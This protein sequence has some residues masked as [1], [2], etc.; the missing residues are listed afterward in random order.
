MLFSDPFTGARSMTSSDT[1]IPGYELLRELG[2]G[3]M[4]TVWLA[5]QR[6]L[7]RKV[8]IKVMKRNIDDLEKFERRF[9]VEGR[10]MAKLPHRNIVAVYD[11]VKGE[12]VTYIAMEYLDGGTLSTKMKEGLS[13]AEAISVVVQIAHALQ[14]A[15]EHGV[16]HRDLKPA[17]IMFRDEATPVLTDFGIAKQADQGSTRLTQ[18][19]MLV[20]TPTY[21]SPEQINALDVDGRSDLYALGILFYELLT[22]APPFQA[23]TP[24]AVLMSHLTQPPPPLPDQF[25]DFQP[26]VDKMLAK[27]RDDRFSDLREFTRDLKSAVVNNA[28]LF[29]RLQADPSQSSS[30]QL[31]ALGFSISGGSATSNVTGPM[32]G[33]IRLPPSGKGVPR[34]PTPTGG[35]RFPPP[36]GDEYATQYQG[37]AKKPP[38]ALIGGGVAAVL[39]IG[40]AA[41]LFWPKPEVPEIDPA[42]KG[43][44]D[45]QLVEVEAL[46]K[47]GDIDAA[48]DQL[49]SVLPA[50]PNYSRAKK[51]LADIGATYRT[52]ADAALAKGDFD[53]AL[54]QI[55]KAKA[56]S[57]D[58]PG[59]AGFQK[60]LEDAKLASQNRK[61]IDDLVARADAAVKA[62]KLVGPGGGYVLLARARQLAPNDAGIKKKFDDLVALALRPAQTAIA[63]RDVATARTSLDALAAELANEPA[64]KKLRA[65][66]DS[67]ADLVAKKVRLDAVL[68]RFDQQLAAGSLLEPAQDN[69]R[70]SLGAAQQIDPTSPD[71]AKRSAALAG[72]LAQRAQ[73]AL[74][75]GRTEEALNLAQSALGVQPDL[76]RATQLK[77]AAEGKLGAARA[78]LI[79]ALTEAK[80]ALA[81]QRFVPPAKPNARD[82]LDAALKLDPANAEAKQLLAELPKRIGEAAEAR[83]AAG[84]V[85]SAQKLVA[86]ARKLYAAE[87][88]LTALSQQIAQRVA[89]EQAKAARVAKLEQIAALVATRPLKNETVQSAAK[90]I[91]ALLAAN[92]ADVD[93]VTLRKRLLDALAESLIAAQTLAE[94]EV[95]DAA[96]KQ[97]QTLLATEQ[98]TPQ[99]LANLTTTRTR[100]EAEEQVRLEAMKGE[101]VLVAY[102]W[103]TVERVEDQQTKKV[104]ALPTDATTPL[105]LSVPQG[106]YSVTFRHPKAGAKKEVARV[107]AKKSSTARGSFASAITTEK[108]LRDAGY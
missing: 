72:A 29:A 62:G 24:I 49:A 21:M 90:E 59:I 8:A 97:A 93:A 86:D 52:A 58:D 70:E 81:E 27:N 30:E 60:K 98:G 66:L 76:A 80:T 71:V 47:A 48:R 17:N 108:Y 38:Y 91:S 3:G 35:Q 25:R 44:V 77:T 53:L 92:A 6:S 13:L 75:A 20:G 54:V 36:G 26:V 79:A 2:Q 67:T 61:Q 87:P 40:V 99:F 16:V 65:D 39:A 78:Q 73:Q 102:P 1:Q 11:I 63:S 101:L 37:P 10:T 68:Q 56:L 107:E 83:L 18:T 33:Q 95:V 46:I 57:P 96:Y 89:G 28:N 4:A 84:E 100:L 103:A 50:A 22:G 69:A 31:R 51:A 64:F 106:V 12:E 94:F 15:H 85:E 5:I 43:L 88:S 9:L 105:R 74:D 42:L 55:E 82:S 45:L 14:F 7:D 34:T 41:V 23:D 104:I 19:G 32:S